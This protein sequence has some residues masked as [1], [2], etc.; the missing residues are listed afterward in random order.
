MTQQV[1]SILGSTGSVGT[2]SL[3]LIAAH[4]DKFRIYALT[5]HR[6]VDKL[7]EQVMAFHPE[8]V[9]V[10]SPEA[11]RQLLGIIGTSKTEVRVGPQ[12]LESVA[13]APEVNTV[14][15]GI[16]GAAGLRPI[17]AAARAGKRILLANKEPLVMTGQL[18]MDAV[19]QGGAL[20]MPVDSEHNAIFQCAGGL[21]AKHV[22]RIT[23]TASGGPFRTFSH[24][25]LKNVT[26]EQAIKHPTWSMGRKIS[27]DS[28]ALMNKG[29][30]VIEACYLFN[31]PAAQVDVVVHPQSIVHALVEYA[32]GSTLAHL[33]TPDMRTPIAHALAWPERM[34]APVKR[35]N[36]T[37]LSH[38]SFEEP[39]TSRFPCLKL[40][41]EALKTGGTAPAILN[42]AN[43]VAVEAFLEGYISFTDIPATI[44]EVL[45][46]CEIGPADT[47]ERVLRADGM[48]RSI[49]AELI[50]ILA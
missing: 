21:E 16:V 14:I 2:Q 42:A 5:A 32:D 9:V 28:A 44:S 20:L 23:L 33:G 29:L 13:V 10:G 48:A 45:S 36:L 31:M 40:A 1:I 6:Q 43:E 50:Q 26:A 15:A 3:S 35:L 37:E 30:E 8:V 7:A 12:G 49:A 27:V 38:L 4:P 46:Q 39:D 41:Y 19:K 25:Q 34:E 18:L 47:I 24:D 11:A 17:L 22:Q